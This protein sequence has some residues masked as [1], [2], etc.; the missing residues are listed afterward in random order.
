MPITALDHQTALV[1]IDLQNGI[2]SNQLAHP[3]QEV[4]DNAAR[5]VNAFR[6]AGRLIVAV[7]V[8][9]SAD[10]GDILRPRNEAPARAAA[11]PPGWDELVSALPLE[12]Q[13][14]RITKHN[15]SA[16]YGT[17][18][19]LQLRRRGI[20]GIVLAG[21][22]TSIGVEGTARGAHERG[23]NI[24]FATDAMTDRSLPAHEHSLHTIFPMIGETGSATAIISKL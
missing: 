19:D 6:Q 1:L 17:D 21:I 7:N 18:L 10:G 24:S 5:L 12:P 15:W 14:I 9:F 3:V 13:D 20:T 2:V 4:L 11:Y 23:Y 22:A 8:S 16:F